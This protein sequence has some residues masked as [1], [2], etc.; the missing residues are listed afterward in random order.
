M[1]NFR[2]GLLLGLLLSA[3]CIA[4]GAAHPTNTI[5]HPQLEYPGP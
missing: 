5:P 3:G 4:Y 1:H 2:L